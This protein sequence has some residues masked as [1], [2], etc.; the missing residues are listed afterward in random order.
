MALS[1]IRATLW[2]L[3]AHAT[4]E[5]ETSERRKFFLFFFERDGLPSP[6]IFSLYSRNF[7]FG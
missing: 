7:E 6:P 3:V 5:K 2:Q 1:L 4:A